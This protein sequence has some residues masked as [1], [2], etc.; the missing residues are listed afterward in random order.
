MKREECFQLGYI[1]KPHGI[2][3][4][5]YMYLDVDH[6]EDYKK[7]ESVF[8][9][10]NNTLVPFFIR[11]MTIRGSKARVRFEGCEDMDQARALKSK[12]VYLPLHHLPV[13]EKHQF[14]YHEVIG[15]SIVDS[16][17]GTLGEIINVYSRSGQDLLAMTYKGREILIPVTD[18]IIGSVNHKKRELS[19]Q[20]PEGLLDIYLED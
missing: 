8:I 19:V 13:L 18:T 11:S 10:I 1:I 3:G 5:V 15:Y 14:Y 7:M 9:D 17:L 12:K 4:D 2:A 6:P 16:A 20:L